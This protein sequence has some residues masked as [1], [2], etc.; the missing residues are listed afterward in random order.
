MLIPQTIANEIYQSRMYSMDLMAELIQKTNQGED[1]CSC[2]R[3]YIV[4][5]K[6]IEIAESYLSENYSDYQP[7]S[8]PS[9]VCLT[10]DEMSELI[11]KMKI[12]RGGNSYPVDDWILASGF[13]SDL[14]H[15]SDGATW[16]D[17]VPIV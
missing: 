17:T 10:E 2:Q 13:W 11:A 1:I 12:L 5:L 4:L 16:N 14:G 15:W 3:K 6:W 7:I 8:D 9:V